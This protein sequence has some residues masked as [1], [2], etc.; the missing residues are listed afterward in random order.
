MKIL[1]YDTKQYDIDSFSKENEVFNYKLKF[2]DFK[3]TI[4]SVELAKGYDTVCVF[5]N[6]N[7]TADII[8]RLHELGVKMIALRCAGYNNIDFKAAY[9]KLHI[10]RV[11]AYSP[12]AVAEHAMALIMTLNRKTHKAYN[13]TKESNFNIGGLTGFDLHGKT[14]GIIGTGKIGQKFI[15]IVN[16]FGMKILAYDKFPNDNLGVEYTDL[17]TLYSKSDIISLHC[18]LLEDTKHIINSDSIDKMKDGVMIINTSRG[19]LINATDLINGLKKRKIGSAGLDVYEEE[20]DYFFEDF[21]EDLITDDKLARLLSFPNVLVTSHQ[22]FLTKEALKNIAETTLGNV[23]AF[24][25][26]EE[27]LNE[28]CYKCPHVGAC[29]K[30]EQ[31]KC[32]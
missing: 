27:L 18:P 16:G 19:A 8:D 22:A 12:Y 5:V 32:F 15:D 21:S 10:V 25:N 1:F 23:K 7:V 29:P 31:K 28:V 6:D 9:G 17:E 26:N 3:L 4:E 20:G 13:R 2:L 14:A 24:T 11:P 30:K